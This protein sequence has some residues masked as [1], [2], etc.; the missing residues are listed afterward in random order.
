MSEG[1]TLMSLGALLLAAYAAHALGARVHIPRVTLLLIVGVLGGPLGLDLLPAG[2]VAWFPHVSSL[3]LAMVG[4]LLGERF[5]GRELRRSGRHVLWVSVAVTT[6]TAGLVFLGLAVAGAPAALALLLAAI[7]PATA[8]AASV[9][10]VREGR[11]HGP[12]TDVTLGVVAVDDAWGVMLFS[13]ALAV[14]AVLDG[15]GAV[16]ELLNGLWEIA[17]AILVG[18]ALGVPMAWLTGRLKKGEPH[19][20]EAAGFVFLCAGVASLMAVSYLMACMTLGAVVANRARHHKRP[21]HTI[22][23]IAEPFL[24]MFFLLAGMRLELVGVGELSV[25]AGV[26]VVARVAGRL[27][28][29]W[30]GA[31]L[32]DAGPVVATRVG[33]CLLP[34]AG[35]SVGLALVAAD[36]FPALG[37][38][39]LRV[40]IA[41]TI[42]FEIVG[43]VLT[44]WQLQAAGEL[45]WSRR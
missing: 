24:A 32:G 25:L 35:V 42:L 31:R 27:S 37:E 3:T 45:E 4:F 15:G 19:L 2:A 17:G 11:A 30:I 28:G 40:I 22:E 39:V 9:D 29:G 6:V 20:V 14:V 16:V 1:L 7:A 34:Q 13:V 43:P 5:A 18:A 33:W 44:R 10:I 23:G 12:L 8:P 26:Y 38:T 41:T 36:R 21:F